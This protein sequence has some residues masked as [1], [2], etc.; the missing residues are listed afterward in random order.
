MPQ[1]LAKSYNMVRNFL[2]PEKDS[3]F[4][5]GELTRDLDHASGKKKD[6]DRSTIGLQYHLYRQAYRRHPA[7]IARQRTRSDG[8]Q[9]EDAFEQSSCEDGEKHLHLVKD[10]ITYIKHV[11][12]ENTIDT[13]M[14]IFRQFRKMLRQEGCK[15]KIEIHRESG[16]YSTDPRI[17]RDVVQKWQREKGLSRESKGRVQQVID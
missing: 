4:D 11:N 5:K 3:Q 13:M 9:D 10:F 7:V 8:K 16:K 1:R 17:V 15:V 14:E 6:D 12:L 2:A